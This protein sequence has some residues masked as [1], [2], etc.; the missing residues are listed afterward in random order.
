MK[1]KKIVA[2]LC[3]IT[4]GSFSSC[5]KKSSDPEPDATTPVIP[6]NQLCDGA[7]GTNYFP[8]DSTDAWI[9][10]LKYSGVTQNPK[11]S[12]KVIGHVT[13]GSFKYA[14]MYDLVFQTDHYYREN[15]STHN[16]YC[17][18]PSNSTDYLEV[19]GTPTLNQTW[20]SAYG[21]RTVTNLNASKTTSS[22]TYSGLL[23]IT[24][25]V[26][27]VTTKFYYKMG[28]GMVYKID[29]SGSFPGEYTLTSATLK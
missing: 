13:Y 29:V 27:S 25:V 12:P 21:T 24:E 7:G 2:L 26:G 14:H 8:L 20:T 5:K 28:L 18:K 11:P 16:I 10:L 15:T 22:C 9:Y 6:V 4:I 23:E 19:P 3:I 17:Y 1:T